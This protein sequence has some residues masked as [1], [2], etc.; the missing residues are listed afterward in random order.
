MRFV[1]FIKITFRFEK[2]SVVS[3]ILHLVL[4][5]VL[6]SLVFFALDISYN[7]SSNVQNN[8]DY[9]V[10][11]EN[12][13]LTV[14]IK[15]NLDVS[16]KSWKI[17]LDDVSLADKVLSNFD[18]KKSVVYS[19]DWVQIGLN[20]YFESHYLEMIDSDQFSPTVTSN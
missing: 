7:L 6:I 15:S 20:G 9:V 2:N 12:N 10:D 8:I 16:N 1:D 14:A 18:Y 5:V 17:D 13:S 4:V 11:K 3:I 19:K